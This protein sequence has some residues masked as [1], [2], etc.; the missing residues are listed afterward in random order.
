MNG[1][2]HDRI[3]AIAGAIALGEASDEERSEYRKHIAACT[4]CLRAL[5][6]EVEIERIAGT[7]AAARDAEM[8]EPALGDVVAKR[9]RRRS[10]LLAWGFSSF[11]LAL[12]ASLG[13]HALFAAGVTRM[14]PVPAAPLVFDAGPTRIV[15]EQS[16]AAAKPAPIAV[17]RRLIVTHNVVQIAR[18]PVAPPPAAVPVTKAQD[19]PEIVAMTVYPN[20]PVRAVRHSKV[21]VWRRDASAWR[22]VAQ[23]TTTSVTETAPQM[24]MHSAESL[25]VTNAVTREVSPVGGESAINPQPAMIAYDEGAEGTTVFEVLVDEHGK[26]TRCVI[27]KSAGYPVLDDAVCSAAMKVRYVP[28]TVDGRAVPGVY[29]DAFT[30]HMS[31]QTSDVQGIPHNV[32][33]NISNAPKQPL[34]SMAQPAPPGYGSGS[35]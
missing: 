35:Y 3:E 4:G 32:P 34:H 9:T 10:R 23:T 6:G 16:A 20:E 24:L 12:A 28:K 14:T 27:T 2:T 25:Q 31:D 5:G 19:P 33:G 21:P 7:V 1:S 29:H 8:W 22:T 30:F 13:V 15:L 18:A 17:A 26:P 11:G